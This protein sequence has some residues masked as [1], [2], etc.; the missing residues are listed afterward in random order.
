MNYACFI[1]KIIEKPT[2]TFYNIRTPVTKFIVQVPDFNNTDKFTLIPAV[3]WGKLGYDIIQYYQTNDYIIIEGYLSIRKN[4]IDEFGISS[5]KK[6]EISIYK[7]Y[8]FLL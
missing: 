5:F 6:I 2:Q 7:I 8:P 4:L 1:V 3:I